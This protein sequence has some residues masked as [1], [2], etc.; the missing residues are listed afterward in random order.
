MGGTSGEQLL[1]PVGGCEPNGGWTRG[2]ENSGGGRHLVQHLPRLPSPR[3]APPWKHTL[4]LPGGPDPTPLHVWVYVCMSVLISP[5]D[6]WACQGKQSWFM[7]YIMQLIFM[8]TCYGIYDFKT[9]T[10]FTFYVNLPRWECLSHV[11]RKGNQIAKRIGD[12]WMSFSDELPNSLSSAHFLGCSP[13]FSSVL[14]PYSTQMWLT[15]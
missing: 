10:S 15:L 9:V 8:S 12:S 11:Y 1:S 7:K 4:L 2:K 3:T 13:I 6:C 5:A 14:L